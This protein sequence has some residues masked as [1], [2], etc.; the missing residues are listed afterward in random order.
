MAQGRFAPCW[1]GKGGC[2][3]FFVDTIIDPCRECGGGMGLSCLHSSVS[4]QTILPSA[5]QNEEAGRYRYCDE[6]RSYGVLWLDGERVLLHHVFYEGMEELGYAEGV[7]RRRENT[8]QG[9]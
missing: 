6:A 2:G 7:I 5:G 1:R 9:E 8:A 4:H 3:I